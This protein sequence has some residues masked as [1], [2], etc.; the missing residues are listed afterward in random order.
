MSTASARPQD[1]EEPLLKILVI[2]ESGVGKTAVI[3]RYV[4]DKFYQ[5]YKATVGVDFALK[6]IITRPFIPLNP[7]LSLLVQCQ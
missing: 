1:H 3:G 7:P 4:H 5:G 2:G 6:V